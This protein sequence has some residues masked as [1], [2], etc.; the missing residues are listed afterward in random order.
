M[1]QKMNERGQALV[2]VLFCSVVAFLFVMAVL[3]MVNRGQHS[4]GMGKR[5]V[6]SLDAADA[7]VSLSVDWLRG[8]TIAINTAAFDSV[9]S[10]NSGVCDQIKLKKPA[11]E[12]GS[13]ST[14]TNAEDTPDLI[15]TL[16]GSG[17]TESGTTP[18]F[19]V[20]V[21]IVDARPGIA[22]KREPGWMS[23]GTIN[24]SGGGGKGT[25]GEGVITPVHLPFF[26]YTVEVV[27]RARGSKEMA[28]LTYIYAD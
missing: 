15:F 4:S 19:D 24:A 23:G 17:T 11:T 9:P 14:T 1:R 22:E 21:K 16:K 3:Y 5:Y 7:G 2:M 18:L 27:G 25:G 28:H 8:E 12:W 20:F 10:E 26:Y 13:C 6:T